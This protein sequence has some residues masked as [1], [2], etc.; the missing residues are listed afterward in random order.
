M[1]MFLAIY[2]IRL[3]IESEASESS[4]LFERACNE[5]GVEVDK[6][7]LR[8]GVAKFPRSIL[9]MSI[10]RAKLDTCFDCKM[11]SAVFFRINQASRNSDPYMGRLVCVLKVDPVLTR[12][13][14][15]ASRNI[16]PRGVR[17]I[18]E[19]F[20]GKEMSLIRGYRIYTQMKTGPVFTPPIVDRY[21][22]LDKVGFDW[23]E[24]NGSY[25]NIVFEN[26]VPFS[27]YRRVVETAMYI[28]KAEEKL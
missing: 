15:I 5:Y 6:I 9:F 22:Y 8:G 7:N 16:S 1:A 10:F 23:V 17:L 28:K 3:Q 20:D 12:R 19:V 14:L 25:V 27:D 13:F 4:G 24:F 26:D 11:H 18:E 2:I 21:R